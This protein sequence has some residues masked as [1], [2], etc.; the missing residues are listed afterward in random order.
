MQRHYLRDFDALDF[1]NRV[2]LGLTVA[3]S[4]F[5]LLLLLKLLMPWLLLL[6]V[7]YGVWYAWQR[8]RQYQQQL[9]QCFYECLQAN[10]GRI[11]VIDFA[12]AARITGP[13]ARKFLDARAKDFFAE[14]ETSVHGD[15]FYTFRTPQSPSD[16]SSKISKI[17]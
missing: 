12:M 14:F 2:G 9:Y 3:F 1:S 4:I 17:L 10:H 8:R 6:G 13:R 7:L 5:L 11:S 16:L 15:I